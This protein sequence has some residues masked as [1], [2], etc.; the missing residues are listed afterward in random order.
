MARLLPPTDE[1]LARVADLRADGLTW[2]AVG[3]EVG[4]AARTVRRWPAKYHDRWLLFQQ[5]AEVQL[6]HASESEAVLVLRRLLRSKDEQLAW[7]AAK[8]IVDMRIN[9]GKI[10]A[11]LPKLSA[12]QTLPPEMIRLFSFLTGLSDAELDSAIA[13]I[14]STPPSPADGNDP[15]NIPGP[16]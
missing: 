4:R 2:E 8:T 10:V 6:A 12:D 9:L 13:A 15:G 7:H 5:S 1:I 16:A 11:K 3:R 14:R